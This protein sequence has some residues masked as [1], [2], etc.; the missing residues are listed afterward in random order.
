MLMI[1]RDSLL[2]VVPHLL[3]V[4]IAVF[5]VGLQTSKELNLDVK[6]SF[7]GSHIEHPWR[8]IKNN[9][10]SCRNTGAH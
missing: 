1:G 5:Q 9:H 7:P 6:N 3:A 10:S 4:P 8:C 2:L